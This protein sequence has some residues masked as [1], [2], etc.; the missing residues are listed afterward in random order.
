MKVFRAIAYS[1]G[2]SFLLLLAVAMPLKYVYGLPQAVKVIGMIHGLL[3]VAY[4][5]VLAYVASENNWSLRKSI[6]GLVASVLPFGPFI[7]ESKA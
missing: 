2:I 6:W 1:E 5:L 7:F 4:V 3:F